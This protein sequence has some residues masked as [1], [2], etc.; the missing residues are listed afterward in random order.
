MD[1]AI[2][3][4]YNQAMGTTR[5]EQTAQVYEHHFRQVEIA[6]ALG[7]SQYYVIEH[8]STFFGAITSP[9]VLLAALSQRTSRIRLGSMIWQLPFHNPMRLAQ[10]I[11]TLDQL[12]HGRV[13]VGTGLGVHEHEYLR[14][15]ID[16]STRRE[17]AEEVLQIMLAAWTQD[18]VNFEGKFFKYDEAFPAPHPYQQPH[19]PI[20]VGVHSRRNIEFAARN[21]FSVAQ[22]I[23]T[24]EVVASKFDYFRQMHREYH[25]A[26]APLP[27]RWL[28]RG[29][30][31]DETDDKAM[32]TAEKYLPGM[33]NLGIDKLKATRVGL[34]TGQYLTGPEDSV[35]N[36]TRRE[37]FAGVRKSH[38]F[39]IKSGVA[40]VGS[41]ETVARRIRE[42]NQLMSGLDVYCAE[43]DLGMP[44]HLI[45]RSIDL[46]GRHVIPAL[47]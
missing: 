16:F 25:G 34:G 18:E 38:E 13:E 32:E 6:E 5:P 1:F 23:D 40:V 3:D 24:E 47:A 4:P 45:E 41:P 28:M 9:T 15:G 35:D 29:V 44:T 22:N 33:F 36:Q 19:P 8:Q 2:W 14:W 42:Q 46:F 17:V 43:F 21:G 12:S 20:W 11:A 30:I 37:V 10:E 26:T 27:K 31:V 39:A 7:F